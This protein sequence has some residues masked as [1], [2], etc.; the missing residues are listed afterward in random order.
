VSA[1]LEYTDGDSAGVSA[2]VRLWFG[3]WM[4]KLERQIGKEL[5][6]YRLRSRLTELRNA[7][8]FGS[9]LGANFDGS[10]GSSDSG[11]E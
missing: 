1:L 6:F 11:D 4:E 9:A 2:E 8:E 3:S 7:Y 5:R 10:N